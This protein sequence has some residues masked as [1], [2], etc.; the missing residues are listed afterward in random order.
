MES[1]VK[2]SRDG[3]KFLLRTFAKLFNYETIPVMLKLN[4]LQQDFIA[5]IAESVT[6]NR[7]KEGEQLPTLKQG[8]YILLQG[9]LGVK[10]HW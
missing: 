5:E 10:T 3:R 6:L 1:A 4:L 7:L 8:M 2:K 9:K